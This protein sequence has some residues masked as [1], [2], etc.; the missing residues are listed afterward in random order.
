MLWMRWG[1]RLFLDEEE[2]SGALFTFSAV[3]HGKR[4]DSSSVHA[5]AKCWT[6]NFVAFGSV[7]AW[8]RSMQCGIMKDELC[9]V[10]M[11]MVL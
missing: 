1:G 2:W 8:G 4:S 11:F 10:E 3:S 6:L 5:D 7:V 9:G